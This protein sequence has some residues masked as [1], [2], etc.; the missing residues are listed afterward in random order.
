MHL[1]YMLA[2]YWKKRK[3]CFLWPFVL[4]AFYSKLCTRVSMIFFSY[5]GRAKPRSLSYTSSTAL[6]SSY[7]I[8]IVC[9]FLNVIRCWL[10]ISFLTKL[11]P[12]DGPYF[13][14]YSK[15]FHFWQSSFSTRYSSVKVI[16]K[17]LINHLLFFELNNVR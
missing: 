3:R 11:Y 12:M 16:K 15:V 13:H 10:G 8:Y 1:A 5:W 2:W 6:D 9:T 4:L 14:I 17:T 7:I